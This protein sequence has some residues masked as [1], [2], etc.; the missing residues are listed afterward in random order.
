MLSATVASL[1]YGRSVGGEIDASLLA[2]RRATLR[3]PRKQRPLFASAYRLGVT[4]GVGVG[5]GLLQSSAYGVQTGDR[6]GRDVA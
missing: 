6:G 3:V 1:V 4:R 5:K 2:R